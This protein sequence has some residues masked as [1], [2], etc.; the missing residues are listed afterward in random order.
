MD[1]KP[2]SADW[3]P[4]LLLIFSLGAALM[5]FS[6]AVLIAAFMLSNAEEMKSMEISPLSG[7][8][9]ASSL[10][11]IG[12]LCLPMGY[13]SLQRL[14]G[15]PVQ[16]LVLPPLRLWTWILLPLLWFV[17]V[18]L[19]SVFYEAPGAL[20]YIPVLHFLAV[21]IPI[22]ILVRAAVNRISLGS[23]LRAWSVLGSSMLFGPTIAILLELTLLVMGIFAAAVLVGAVNPAA[24]DAAQRLA[25]NVQNAPDLDS[26]LYLLAP[27][28][29]HPLTLAAALLFL[30]IFTPL[31][32]ETTKSL[33]VWLVSGRLSSLRQGF[34]LGMISGAG[35]ALVESLSAVVS[36]D[37]MWGMAFVARAFS[38]LMHIL[39]A[40][41]TGLGIAY[42]RLQRR[43]LHF[44]GLFSLGMAVHGV[45][46][47]GAALAV[48]GGLRITLS[49][50]EIDLPGALLVLAGVFVIFVMVTLM[51]AG[52]LMLN[53]RL[54]K[55]ET[56]SLPTSLASQESPQ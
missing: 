38:S 37:E 47:G 25:E 39:A 42:A 48:L 35:F 6:A 24:L 36:P 53:V 7:L 11:V 33:G 5:M 46:N 52:L 10:T 14:R 44:L 51:A 3:R 30:S 21:T 28:I 55:P 49:D 26:L 54:G 32:E 15:R 27:V 18:V 1:D 50:P 9:F 34:A 45:W 20:F 2:A 4:I 16:E 40:G 43:Y 19:A 29:R 22:Y 23:H 17:L 8:L 56:T 31:I 12:A 13:Y 41:L